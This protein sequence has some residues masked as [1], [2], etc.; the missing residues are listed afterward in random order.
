MLS[1]KISIMHFME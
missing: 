1:L